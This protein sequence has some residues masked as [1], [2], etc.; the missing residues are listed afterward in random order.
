MDITTT[1]SLIE[2]L[3][4]C[5]STMTALQKQKTDLEGRLIQQIKDEVAAQ[6]AD[7]DYGTGTA[8]V[9]VNGANVKVVISKKVKWDEAHLEAL[10]KDLTE[11]GQDAKEYIDLSYSVAENRYQAW[12]SSLQ[13]LFE[14]AR[15]VEV[16]KPT[17]TI[18]E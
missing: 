11:R 17:I 5:K 15:T 2:Q 16:S 14:P 13:G 8:R 3:K 4:V 10:F 9:T 6:L 1:H 18:E 12:P 7:K